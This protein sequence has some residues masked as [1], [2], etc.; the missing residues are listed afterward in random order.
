MTEERG[1]EG[2]RGGSSGE[3][4]EQ[5]KGNGF[6][7]GVDRGRESTGGLDEGDGRI[8]GREAGWKELGRAQ[9]T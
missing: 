9:S 8:E 6:R 2:M 4:W 7:R 3:E 5:T 1:G